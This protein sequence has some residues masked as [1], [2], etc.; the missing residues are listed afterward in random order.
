[1]K[2]KT[3]TTSPIRKLLL[4]TGATFSLSLGLA[5]AAQPPENPGAE[6]GGNSTASTGPTVTANTDVTDAM[7]FLLPITFGENRL[8]RGSNPV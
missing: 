1:M 4:L 5:R 2:H 7:T 8:L 6:T 3:L